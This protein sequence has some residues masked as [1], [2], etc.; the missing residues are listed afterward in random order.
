[1]AKNQ[2]TKNS[3]I[4]DANR[5]TDDLPPA[6]NPKANASRIVGEAYKDH[7][8]ALDA[9][10]Y[11]FG[12]NSL[13]PLFWV[14]MEGIRENNECEIHFRV[15][16]EDNSVEMWDNVV[17]MTKE[18]LR[19][20]YLSIGNPGSEKSGMDT[21][22]D[23]GK[24]AW[25]MFGWGDTT[26]V[27]TL[28]LNGDR[29]CARA[30]PKLV[31]DNHSEIKKAEAAGEVRPELSH[32]GLY[33]RVEGIADGE[34]ETLCNSQNAIQKIEEK[35][36]FA[37]SN[38]NIDAQFTYEVDGVI[39]EAEGHD[40]QTAAE[41]GAV[42]ANE[43][44]GEFYLQGETRELTGLTLIKTSDLPDGFEPP[45]Q[46]VCMLKGSAYTDS[47]PYMNVWTYSPTEAD[48]ILDG[49]L[50]GWVNAS[51]LCPDRE[52]HGHTG[53]TNGGRI[54]SDSGLRSRVIE[55]CENNFS[56]TS[57]EDK[58]RSAQQTKSQLVDYLNKFNTGVDVTPPGPPPTD[59]TE[60]T[61]P[62]EPDGPRVFASTDGY[63]YD[64]GETVPLHVLITNPE[65]SDI[66]RFRVQTTVQ[67]VIDESGDTIPE[68][69][70]SDPLPVSN[71]KT[72]PTGS[73]QVMMKEEPPV[74]E[75]P[76][77]GGY[78]MRLEMKEEPDMSSDDGVMKYKKAV[79]EKSVVDSKRHTFYIG[80]I[81]PR[82]GGGG[83]DPDPGPGSILNDVGFIQKEDASYR[84]NLNPNPDGTQDVHLN[85]AHSEWQRMIEVMGGMPSSEAKIEL[86]VKWAF[87]RFTFK[88]LS[89][90]INDMLR[91]KGVADSELCL[92]IENKID[93]R[94]ELYD[95]FAE[96][97][98][99]IG[100]EE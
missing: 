18:K 19:E 29:W 94:L 37:L 31:K 46:G 96:E 58:S 54:Y 24:G 67:R 50:W 12:Q 43:D 38:P 32:A 89:G 98:S 10:L 86:G 61:E 66:E 90:E 95:E 6:A 72:I 42:V 17:G 97:F 8:N 34:M 22:G 68:D 7:D 99:R 9:F 35:F 20:N 92:N 88:E 1:M 75:P 25:S 55:A 48:E 33:I 13:D 65:S 93:E 100:D 4:T 79:Q 91:D 45:W 39:S 26:Y 83:T 77:N 59:D 5:E 14:V 69:E 80:D 84:V 21:G 11:E 51:S 15:N 52:E 70:R 41:Q 40:L 76:R 71:T 16:P 3:S 62:T 28:D 56:H 23:Q 85:E 82:H 53:F 78:D 81:E 64:I 49:E 30:Y 73:E 57:V 44:L 74:F 2:P 87:Q 27:E 63:Y 60:P 36:A 47:L